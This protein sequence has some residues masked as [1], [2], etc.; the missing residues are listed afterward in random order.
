GSLREARIAYGGITRQ[1]NDLTLRFK[2]DD[3]RKKTR[4]IVEK[5]FRGLAMREK[6]CS[7]RPDIIQPALPPMSSRCLCAGRVPSSHCA[8]CPVVSRQAR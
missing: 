6:R 2:D 7:Q 5:E 3:A 1:G 8:M 4:A